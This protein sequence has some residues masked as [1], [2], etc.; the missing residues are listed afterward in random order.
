[1]STNYFKKG[2]WVMVAKDNDNEGYNSF[3][4]KKLKI[5]HVAHNTN[6]HPGYDNSMEGMPLY[7]LRDVDGNDIGS[8]LYA[9]ELEKYEKAG[10]KKT[11]AM[12]SAIVKGLNTERGQNLVDDL[13]KRAIA[14]GAVKDKADWDKLKEQFILFIIQINPEFMHIMA[15]DVYNELRNS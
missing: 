8:S 3:R 13:L 11:M 5:T 4:G 9:Y 2:Q 7:D 6:D 15:K 12:T 14:S 1:M 10:M